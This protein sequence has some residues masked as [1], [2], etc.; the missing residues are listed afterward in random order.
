MEV[1]KHERYLLLSHEIVRGLFNDDRDIGVFT[2]TFI[3]LSSGSPRNFSNNVFDAQDEGDYMSSLT[4][5]SQ[6]GTDKGY[7]TAYGWSVEYKDEINVDLPKARAMVKTLGKIERGL[8]RC[9]EKWG[10]INDFP[11]YVIRIANIM[12]V[13]GIL[14]RNS[15]NSYSY[16]DNIYQQYAVGEASSAIHA[17]GYEQKQ[18]VS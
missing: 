1:E 9:A 4:I 11:T 10:Y 17:L 14:V 5:R 7:E 2:V 6:Y 15:G 16:D 3:Y 12:K 13:A 8:K 18:L